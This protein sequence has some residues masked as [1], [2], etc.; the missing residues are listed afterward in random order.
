MHIHPALQSLHL[1]LGRSITSSFLWSYVTKFT[2]HG[3]EFADIRQ[4]AQGD[5]IK[6]IDWRTSA[7]KWEWYTKEFIEERQL[8]VW[9]VKDDEIAWWDL[10][11]QKISECIYAIWYAAIKNWDRL[12]GLMNDGEDKIHMEKMSGKRESLWKIVHWT[13]KSPMQ[14]DE[15]IW[16]R[17]KKRLSY[18]LRW[19]AQEN[20]SKISL[21]E[22]LMLMI[23]LRVKWCLIVLTTS[24]LWVDHWLIKKL[25]ISNEILFVHCF[26]SAMLSVDAEFP[27]VQFWKGKKSMVVSKKQVKEK[28]SYLLLVHKRL[29]SMQRVILSVWW[30]YLI[31]NEKS[32]VVKELM[33]ILH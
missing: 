18:I 15:H 8:R 10:L 29:E 33:W 11:K 19:P 26:E 14:N 20:E 2:W 32:D 3:I 1:K 5:S 16:S 13:H 25:W 22:Y 6:R 4:Y 24:D 17:L 30:K 23:R 27:Y 7:K 21:N 28:E 31:L 9:F 12:W